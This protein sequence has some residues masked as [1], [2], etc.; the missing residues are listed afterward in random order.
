M[1]AVGLSV[2]SKTVI[3]T[4]SRNSIL[5]AIVCVLWVANGTTSFVAERKP[6]R[7]RT[8]LTICSWATTVCPMAFS[9]ES[10]S[11]PATMES[12]LCSIPITVPALC[13]DCSRAMLVSR[14][15]RASHC[16]RLSNSPFGSSGTIATR[17]RQSACGAQAH[18]KPLQHA[19]DWNLTK[20][21]LRA[22]MP[23]WLER[24]S[25]RLGRVRIQPSS[26]F[27]VRDGSRDGRLVHIR[28]SSHR[29]DW[30][31]LYTTS[32]RQAH[33]RGRTSLAIRTIQKCFCKMRW[34]R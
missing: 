30:R 31:C 11:S 28:I 27:T 25:Y 1:V 18:A 34:R 21:P 14:L 19:C 29:L 9:S 13:G 15:V 8:A 7:R 12:R 24:C 23:R 5:A 32:V 26:C 17:S 6:V 3:M 33:Q 10:T 4:R 22:K 16:R 2:T 20:F